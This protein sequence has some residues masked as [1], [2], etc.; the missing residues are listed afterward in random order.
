MGLDYTIWFNDETPDTDYMYS[1][2]TDETMAREHYNGEPS[3]F[4]PFVKNGVRHAF[5][6]L[7]KGHPEISEAK[8]IREPVKILGRNGQ[9]DLL[10]NILPRST[11][12]NRTITETFVLLGQNA[13]SC[14]YYVGDPGE[15][16]AMVSEMV[17]YFNSFRGQFRIVFSDDP[18]FY[19]LGA[20]IVSAETE[21]YRAIITVTADV[22]PYKYERY[23][24]AEDWI[25]DDF[26]FVDGIIRE[27]GTISLTK[28]AQEITIPVR[29]GEIK[30]GFIF[31]DDTV[32]SEFS[33]LLA[34]IEKFKLKI[35]Y[36]RV[37]GAFTDQYWRE[38][39]A[40]WSAVNTAYTTINTTYYGLPEYVDVQSRVA[41]MVTALGQDIAAEQQ[42]DEEIMYDID[43]IYAEC[44]NLTKWATAGQ[45]QASIDQI[46]WYS[47]GNG[48]NGNVILPGADR[49]GL[50]VDRTLSLCG[51]RNIKL[52]I[53]GATL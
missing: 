39:N 4:A 10:K 35:G 51:V 32:P 12:E 44:D 17:N 48:S 27:Y 26:S 28:N 21:K 52:D 5:T 16:S 49:S 38:V 36:G 29:T 20:V 19:W 37:I 42:I 25:W 9:P 47:V 8:L 30:P 50:I 45:V 7:K 24:S 6:L 41:A 2:G 11:Y 22:E 3:M 43:A 33:A 40:L 1:L 34:A 46:H 14:N 53:R 15:W 23:S 18:G 31:D 13:E